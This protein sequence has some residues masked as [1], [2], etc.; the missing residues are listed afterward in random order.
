VSDLK[1]WWLENINPKQAPLTDSEIDRWRER[2]S[3]A[4]ML[5]QKRDAAN[6]MRRAIAMLDHN[7]GS[8]KPCILY[9]DEMKLTQVLFK[10]ATIVWHPWRGTVGM[11]HA[12]DL[13]YCA[14]TGELVG[15]QIWDDVRS[16]PAR[17]AR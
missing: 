1:C 12:V 9:L 16:P 17:P 8:F 11:G 6:F 2:L 10:D 14:D 3:G 5:W 13:G 4:Q 15:I 7:D